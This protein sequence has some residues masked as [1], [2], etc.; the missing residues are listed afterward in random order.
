MKV[1]IYLQKIKEI[2]LR[3]KVVFAYLFGSQV[4]GDIGRLSDVDIALYL[5]EDLNDSKRFNMKL[6][7]MG[8]LSAL[9]KRDDIDIV[10]LNDAYPLLEHRIIKQG[11]VIFSEDEKKRVD[12]EVKAVMRYLDFKPFIEKHTKETLYGR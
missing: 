4:K 6:K 9:F 7:I 3:H 10:I 5:D 12:Y 8:E 2:F 11:E 1:K